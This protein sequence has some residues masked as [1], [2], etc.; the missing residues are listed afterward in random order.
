MSVRATFRW[1]TGGGENLVDGAEGAAAELAGNRIG[2]VEIRINHANQPHR[3]ALLLEFPVNAGM[4]APED[5]HAYYCDRYGALSLQERIS[6]GWLPRSTGDC[7]GK[8]EGL[9]SFV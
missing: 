8:V 3:F 2:A 9:S 5:A 4:V 7:N 6:A 1:C